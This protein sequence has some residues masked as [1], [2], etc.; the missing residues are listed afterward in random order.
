MTS[1]NTTTEAPDATL[2][3]QELEVLRFV[4][5]RA[6]VTVREVADEWGAPR[7]R[8]RTTI[9]TVME[10]LRKKGFLLRE[11]GGA[12]EGSFRYRPAVTPQAVMQ[13][14][15]RDF[16]QKTLGGSVAP[17][18]AYLADTPEDLSR[19]EVEELR[20]LVADMEK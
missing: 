17:F 1:E 2:G 4:S 14:L 3:D 11:E 8:A 13:N 18:V 12:G 16:V 5:E 15:V 9:L 10:R 19:S 6:P 20:K 7:G